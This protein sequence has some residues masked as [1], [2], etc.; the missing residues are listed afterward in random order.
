MTLP[1]SD[2]ATIQLPLHDL[3]RIER[4]FDA[5]REQVATSLQAGPA[6]DIPELT[7][8][9]EE[10]LCA[11]VPIVG[12]AIGLLNPES[13]PGWP[14]DKLQRVAQ[15]LPEVLPTMD[16]V[17]AVALTWQDVARSAA[18]IDA[19]RVRRY[20]AAEAIVTATQDTVEGGNETP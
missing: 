4:E 14:H 18:E 15:L 12:F 10:A 5:L 16:D 13:Y 7:R 20:R 3:R 9:L 2:Q 8:K 19:Y 11:A 1:I 17:Q 6:Q